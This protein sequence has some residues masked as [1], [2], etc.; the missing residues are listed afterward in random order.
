MIG[1]PCDRSITWVTW[2]L[3]TPGYAIEI[4]TWRE[5]VHLC[6]H[7]PLRGLPV[8]L[9]I[10]TIFIYTTATTVADNLP[11]TTTT[12]VLLSIILIYA[13]ET[14]REICTSSH[15]SLH[16]RP[17]VLLP[18]CIIIIYATATVTLRQT[19]CHCG[20]INIMKIGSSTGGPPGGTCRLRCI[21]SFQVSI[22][23]RQQP[24]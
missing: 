3:G 19:V 6:S 9:P 22:T 20:C 11:L 14:W 17:S 2:H 13:I 5:I 21:I 23:G 16:R 8:L 4:G 24:L 12:L 18:I 7:V 15:M 1:V 10:C